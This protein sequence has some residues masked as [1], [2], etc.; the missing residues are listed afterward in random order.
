[1]QLIRALFPVPGSCPQRGHCGID[2]TVFG[3]RPDRSDF[4][5]HV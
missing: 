2:A 3:P 5:Q 4:V 1:M